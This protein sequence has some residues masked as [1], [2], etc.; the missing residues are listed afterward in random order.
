MEVGGTVSL[1]EVLSEVVDPRQPS[2]G[3]LHDFREILVISVC[4]LLSDADKV[5]A[6]L[7]CSER[8]SMVMDRRRR[9]TVLTPWAPD[10]S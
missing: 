7:G 8:S 9:N 1:M 3:T 5:S 4:A 2:N 6:V 10:R